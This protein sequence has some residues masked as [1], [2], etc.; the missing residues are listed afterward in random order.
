MNMIKVM[1]RPCLAGLLTGLQL[2]V[3]CLPAAGQDAQQS[4]DEIRTELQ[5]QELSETAL[6]ALAER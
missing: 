3:F 2:L 4:A 6:L 5:Q 1:S